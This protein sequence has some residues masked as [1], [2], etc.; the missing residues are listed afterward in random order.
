M[1]T[2]SQ[3]PVDIRVEAPLSRLTQAHLLEQFATLLAFDDMAAARRVV[4]ERFGVTWSEELEGASL[5]QILGGVV[6]ADLA[7]LCDLAEL[8]D[9]QAANRAALAAYATA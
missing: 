8:S 7:L 6:D 4:G 5:G 9:A 3:S 2:T 1:T